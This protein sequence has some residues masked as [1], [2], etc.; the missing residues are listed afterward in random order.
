MV[1]TNLFPYPVIPVAFSLAKALFPLILL[2]VDPP[3]AW[4]AFPITK[5]WRL[6]LEFECQK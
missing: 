4:S 1:A 5:V 3:R 2:L 6:N